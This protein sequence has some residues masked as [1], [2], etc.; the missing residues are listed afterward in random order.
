M[1]NIRDCYYVKKSCGPSFTSRRDHHLLINFPYL[2]D[3]KLKQ[4]CDEEMMN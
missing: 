1:L 3:T 2:I 4:R